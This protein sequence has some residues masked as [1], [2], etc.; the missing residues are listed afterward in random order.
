MQ[1]ARIPAGLPV[2]EP[3]S[4]R[5]T[6][7]TGEFIRERI[8][9]NGGHISFGEFMHYALYAPG[10]GYY[11]AGSVKFSAGGDFVTAPE[12]SPLFGRIVA[13]QCAPVLTTI[14]TGSV[15]ELGAGSG[16]LAVEVLRTLQAM[17]ALPDSYQIL[18][19]SADLAERQRTFIK[20]QTPELL[21]RVTWLNGLPENFDGV[22]LAN[23]VADALPVERFRVGAE[24]LEQA[25]VVLAD[26]RGDHDDHDSGFA[27][28]WCPA[29]EPLV[30]AVRALGLDLP[31]GYVSEISLGLK[32]WVGELS[33]ALGQGLI[34]LFDYGLS[35]REYYAADRSG[36]WLRCH[37]RHRAH[38]E[39]LVY[40]GIQ[41]VTAWVDFTA[42]AEAATTSGAAVAGFVTQAMFLLHGGLDNEFAAAATPEEQMRLAREAK[43]LTLPTE[44]GENF[45]C[46]GLTKGHVPV[47]SALVAADRTAT[48]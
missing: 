8:A 35:R 32:P 19:V 33:A 1:A 46:I 18:E 37:F 5:H 36:G 43:L 38:G 24:G 20:A 9:A 12:V 6:E 31:G 47:P 4:L 23:E 7:R 30:A 25:F 3:E 27:I 39:P 40:P 2:P 14:K 48:L 34:L 16:A 10:L 22:V 13:R 17:D 41:D 15:L 42:V 45:K 28:D 11:T 21:E 26:D 29:A 44:M